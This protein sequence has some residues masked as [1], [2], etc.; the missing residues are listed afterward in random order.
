MFVCIRMMPGSATGTRAA[1]QRSGAGSRSATLRRPTSTI[2]AIGLLQVADAFAPVCFNRAEIPVAWAPTLEL[3]V[4]IRSIP[5]PGPL[6]CRLSSRFIQYGMFEEDGEIWD[7]TGALVA[8]SR[9]L[10]LIPRV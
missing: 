10:A 4:H 3:T 7:S 2:D 9:Q 1:A 5:A 6:R 8:Q